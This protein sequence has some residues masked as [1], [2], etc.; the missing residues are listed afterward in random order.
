MKKKIYK[1]LVLTYIMIFM[2]IGI[3]ACGESKCDICGEIA[4]CKKIR[5]I[6]DGEKMNLCAD[7]EQGCYDALNSMFK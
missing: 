4:E 6:E 7:C 1:S 5:F 2:M 3:T